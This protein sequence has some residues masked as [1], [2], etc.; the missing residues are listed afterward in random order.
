MIDRDLAELY[1]VETKVLNQAIKRNILR[2]PNAFRFQL[3]EDELKELVTNCDRFESLKHTSSN[4][5]AFTEQGV[6]MASAIL[7][8]DIAVRV[9]VQI[10]HALWKCAK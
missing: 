2:F 10:I 9:S 8:S 4:P 5:F 3:D 6:A 7:K 1:Q